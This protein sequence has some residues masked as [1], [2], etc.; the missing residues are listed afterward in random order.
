MV[1]GVNYCFF[2]RSINAV[3]IEADA[4]AMAASCRPEKQK[5]DATVRLRYKQNLTGGEK[6]CV[7]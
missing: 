7:V 1:P 3:P 6:Q 4:G 2:P 5:L